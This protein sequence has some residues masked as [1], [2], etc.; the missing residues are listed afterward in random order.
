MGVASDLTGQPGC[1][2][3]VVLAQT[4]PGLTGQPDQ[5]APCR[6]IQP[7]IGR[8]RDVLFHHRGVDRDP[9]EIVALHRPGALPGL[10]RLGQHP[11]DAFLANPLAPTGQ[12]RRINRQTVLKERF[13]AEMLP[14][15]VLGPSGHDRLVRERIGMLKIKQAS[16]QARQGRRAT[17]VGRKEPDPFPLENIPVNQGFQLHQF[18]AHVD[19]LDQS[20]AQEIVLLRQRLSWLHIVAQNCRVSAR[21]IRTPCTPR[22]TETPCFHTKSDSYELFRAD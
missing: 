1:E 11:F 22:P 14:V 13:T 4:N 3:V 21:I 10:D 18:M 7:G 9:L 15:R 2:A 19:H 12:G 17:G 16:D 5:F 20:G 6:F 8:V